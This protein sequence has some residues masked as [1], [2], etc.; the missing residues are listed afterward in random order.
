MMFTAVIKDGRVLSGAVAEE[1]SSSITLV[2]VDGMRTKIPRR[3]LASFKSA[4]R[5]LMPE[6]LEKAISI[7]Q[8]AD[9][10]TYLKSAGKPMPQVVGKRNTIERLDAAHDGF[11]SITFDPVPGATGIELE[12][13]NAG[14]YKHWTVREIEADANF[15]AKVDIIAGNV[16]P[17]PVRTGSNAFEKAFDDDVKTLTFTTPSYTSAAPQRTLL[18]LEPGDHMLDRIRINTVAGNDGNGRMRKITVRVTTDANPDLAAR[19][20]ANV[21]N[22]SVQIFGEAG[23]EEVRHIGGNDT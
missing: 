13:A 1:T 12:W 16:L 6:G 10:L 19:K 21:A 3:R 14:G 15:D 5:S 9:L 7:D 17:G 18:K 20:Y 2:S 4:R 22:L 8:M 23:A 11:Y